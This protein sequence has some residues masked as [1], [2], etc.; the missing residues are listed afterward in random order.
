MNAMN[1]YPRVSD[2]ID[3]FVGPR[4]HDPMM[5]KQI[6]F[7]AVL[8]AWAVV[9]AGTASADP[10]DPS[11]GP[12]YQIPTP[13]GPSFPGTQVYAPRCLVAPLACGLHYDASTGTWQ[14]G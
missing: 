14:P 5:T 11:L 9:M 12:G 3:G 2:E 4:G 8:A 1:P 6:I 13:N 7:A 10:D